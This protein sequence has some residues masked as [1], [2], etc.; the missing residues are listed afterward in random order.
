MFFSNNKLERRES[1]AGPIDRLAAGE[2]YGEE[3]RRV[4]EP[5]FSCQ[6]DRCGFQAA[7]SLSSLI[8]LSPLNRGLNDA[9]N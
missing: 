2:G 5:S 6:I 1:S 7:A 4:R 8:E 3:S 9:T